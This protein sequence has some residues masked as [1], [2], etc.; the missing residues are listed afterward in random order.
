MEITRLKEQLAAIRGSAPVK[1]T[2]ETM[3]ERR[4]GKGNPVRDS[5]WERRSRQLRA[6]GIA[7][8]GDLEGFLCDVMYQATAGNKRIDML[9]SL[10]K[11]AE[12]SGSVELY[13]YLLCCHCID[14]LNE[15][16]MNTHPKLV[17]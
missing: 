7:I 13:R 15:I 10:P 1:P 14:I 9:L 16:V 2:R 17:K 8:H 12:R 6:A 3:V 5:V 4:G 11:V